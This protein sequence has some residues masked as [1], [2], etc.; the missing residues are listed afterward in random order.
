M[1]G[2]DLTSAGLAAAPAPAVPVEALTV[3]QLAALGDRIANRTWAAGLPCWFWG[4]G[5]Y[6]L[7]ELRLAQALGR[8]CPA[9]I[10]DWFDAQVRAGVRVEHVNDLAPGTAA[11]LA[12]DAGR[13]SYLGLVRA[14]ATWAMSDSLAS[15]APGGALE[16]WPGALWADTTLMAAVPLGHLGAA[17]G[18]RVLLIECGR[19]LVAH[20]ETLQHPRTALYAH[21]SH[22]GE[23]LWCYWARGNAWAALAGVEFLELVAS[24]P[25]GNGPAPDLSDLAEAIADALRRQLRALAACQPSHG[26]WDVL[27]D[28]WPETAGI[29]DASAVA[30]IAAAALRAAQV[31]PD[32]GDEVTTAGWRAARAALSFVADD[33]TLTRTSAGTVLQLVPFGYS[34]IRDDR[35]QL[36]GQGLALHAVAAVLDALSRGEWPR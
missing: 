2:E 24:L 13:P 25:A 4:E 36:W 8:P 35:L 5:V 7:G 21:G 12:A 26:A 31:V 27:V 9:R 14:L 23:T 18:D 34:V 11:V 3:T 22:R 10:L 17:T 33:G 32:L 16:H 28:G 1:V 30:G 19:Q 15:R 6:L 29:V 20:A